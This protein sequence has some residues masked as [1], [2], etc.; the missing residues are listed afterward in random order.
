MTM[1]LRTG[2]FEGKQYQIYANS[3]K[4]AFEKVMER[5]SQM[6]KEAQ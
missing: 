4:K 5:M 3:D 1:K 2:I 6:K